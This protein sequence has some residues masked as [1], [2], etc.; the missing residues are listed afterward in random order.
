M[1]MKNILLFVCVLVLVSCDKSQ[2]AI[3]IYDKTPAIV[4]SMTKEE[5]A[6]KMKD[7]TGC[8]GLTLGDTSIKKA[9]SIMKK[10]GAN[11]ESITLGEGCDVYEGF[12]EITLKIEV[13]KN[14]TTYRSEFKH[15]YDKSTY[16][17][18]LFVN[19]TLSIIA[20]LILDREYN[21]C[22]DLVEKYGVGNGEKKE[23][24]F[25]INKDGSINLNDIVSGYEYRQWQNE[26]VVI[27]WPYNRYLY[28]ISNER[29]RFEPA[30]SIN[31]NIA[32]YTSKKMAKRIIHYYK[33]AYEEY[34]NKKDKES[35][36]RIGNL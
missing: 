14:I 35:S 15:S 27:D 21:L 13:P 9:R 2:T 25:G 1:N 30:V 26:Q 11:F 32:I 22:K 33:K 28:K 34:K 4:Y 24:Q 36:E 8:Y 18:M 5:E 10:Q 6:E 23:T 12:N 16:V 17:Y 3:S 20:P 29:L 19:D 7:V 31:D